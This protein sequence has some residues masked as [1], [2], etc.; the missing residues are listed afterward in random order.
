[1]LVVDASAVVE[2][3]VASPAGARVAEHLGDDHTLHAPDLL[4]V[5]VVSVLR[6]LGARREL[7]ATAGRRALSDFVALGVETY[8]HGPL[9]ARSLELGSL[10]SAY[11]A[12]YVA[13][14]EGLGAPL[15][16]CDA[17]LARARG[18]DAEVVLVGR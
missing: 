16:T 2:F 4:G 8:E 5:E 1:M 12:V 14:A 3:L 6:K 7:S 9:L 10:L 15:L 11:D 17:K 13:L 18:H